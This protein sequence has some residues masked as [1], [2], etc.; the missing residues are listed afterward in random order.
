MLPEAV[1]DRQIAGQPAVA[2]LG[3]RVGHGVS[4]LLAQGLNEPLRF[5]VCAG[6]V[7]PGADVSEAQGAAGL[8]ERLGDI[9][10]AFVAHHPTALDALEVEPG[11]CTTKKDDHR[12]LVLVRQHFT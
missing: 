7:G 1:I 5:A 6:R 2:L 10:R 8:V 3:V 4:P 12:W 11:D 9:G